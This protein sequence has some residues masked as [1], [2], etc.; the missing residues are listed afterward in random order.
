MRTVLALTATRT[1]VMGV[2]P[3]PPIM[4]V[5][6]PLVH[7]TWP[8]RGSWFSKVP[9]AGG[10]ATAVP[11]LSRN[12]NASSGVSCANARGAGAPPRGTTHVQRR[13]A[14]SYAQRSF[15]VRVPSKPPKTY[16]V[17]RRTHAQCP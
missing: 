11:P 16:I 2:L 6:V 4:K 14:R 3:E 9:N 10:V 15:R 13:A 7:V 5:L 17:W 12:R 8:T 1:E